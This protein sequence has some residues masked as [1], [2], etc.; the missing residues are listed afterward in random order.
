MDVV[1]AVSSIP[2]SG[3]DSEATKK[4]IDAITVFLDTPSSA[5]VD[6]SDKLGAFT[7]LLLRLLVDNGILDVDTAGSLVATF[8]KS[9][10]L[11]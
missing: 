8:S 7:N 10:F 3:G 6:P 1:T 9:K 4:F 5:S 11:N 2:A